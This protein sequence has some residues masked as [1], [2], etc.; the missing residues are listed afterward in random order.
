M[1][2]MTMIVVVVVVVIADTEWRPRSR[3]VLNAAYHEEDCPIP[4]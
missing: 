3:Q 1:V 2:M 4:R